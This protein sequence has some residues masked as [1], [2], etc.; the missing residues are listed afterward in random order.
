[1]TRKKT[2][3]E[4]L[5][6]VKEVHNGNIKVIGHYIN[7][8]TKITHKCKFGHEWGSL[9]SNILKGQG[10]PKCA[11]KRVSESQKKTHKD[12]IREVFEIHNGDIEVRDKYINN[13]TKIKHDCK[14]CNYEWETAPINIIKGRGCPKCGGSMKKTHEDY[15]KEVEE[16][17]NGNIK[18]EGKYINYPTKITHKCN[19]CWHKWDRTPSDILRGRG[20][21][22]C[23]KENYREA[24]TKSHEQYVREVEE[25]HNGDVEVKEK[26]INSYTKIKHGCK[27]GHEWEAVPLNIYRGKGCPDCHESKGERLV[28]SILESLGV[29]FRSQVKFKELGFDKHVRL[30]C[31][32]VVY[33][34]NEPIFVIE[35]N[36]I[37]HYRPNDFFGGLEGYKKTKRRDETKRKMLHEEG[38][39]VIDIPY[40][41]TEE[42]VKETIEYFINYF[43][44]KKE[45][46]PQTSTQ[47]ELKL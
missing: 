40:S 39:T 38:I 31:D 5:R 29:T 10:C 1:M 11:T 44:I 34:D 25:V 43:N 35:Y 41:E 37:Q 45:Q 3:E 18:V 19:V 46:K 26:Y 13:H 42:Q 21:P 15:L 20:C 17:H 27:H 4:Y 22:K 28:S 32:F 6:E 12:Y 2:H 33:K 36:G 9:S 24:R 14:I 30:T 7:A 16:K 47:L 8:K 23:T